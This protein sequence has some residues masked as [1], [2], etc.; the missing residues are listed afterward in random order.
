[1][2]LEKVPLNNKVSPEMDR[3]TVDYWDQFWSDSR[4]PRRIQVEGSDLRHTVD[5]AYYAAIQRYLYPVSNAQ[6][7]EIGC[8]NSSWLPFFSSHLGANVAGLDYSELACQRAKAFMNTSGVSGEIRHG[9]F[10]KP[11]DDWCN[12]FDMVFTNGLVEH[13]DDTPLALSQIARFAK[14]GGRLIT[15]IP[16][17]QGVNGWL[18]K[19]LGRNTFD[20]HRVLSVD[21]LRVAHQQAGLSVLDCHYLLPMNF[22]V[23]NPE[24]PGFIKQAF[25]SATMAFTA[26]GWLLDRLVTLPRSAVM[27]PYVFCCAEKGP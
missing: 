1:M 15:F 12:R 3:T 8:G 2:G 20:T 10:R 18:Q 22:L 14:P 17:M 25:T 26:A 21:A 4:Q 27:A 19:H 11:P 6:I 16:N 23:V 13:F 7:I 24:L 5:R 9:D